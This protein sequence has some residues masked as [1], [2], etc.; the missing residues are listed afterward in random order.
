MMTLH[1]SV[2]YLEDEEEEISLKLKFKDCNMFLTRAR[3]TRKIVTKMDT[4]G[5]SKI[6]TDILK[7][8]G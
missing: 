7:I 1:Q 5:E 6:I 4:K 3:Q 2:A 8:R